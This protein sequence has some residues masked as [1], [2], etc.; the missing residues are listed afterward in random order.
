MFF[1]N[2]VGLLRL[3]FDIRSFLDDLIFCYCWRIGI[4]FVK[5]GLKKSCVFILFIILLDVVINVEL[6]VF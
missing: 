1:Y 4:V 5:L 6:M 2:C 3:L